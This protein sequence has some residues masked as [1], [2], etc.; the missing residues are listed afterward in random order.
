[1]LTVAGAHPPNRMFGMAK[2][3]QRFNHCGIVAQLLHACIKRRFVRQLQIH[4][5]VN[6]PILHNT[7]ADFVISV[8]ALIP[9]LDFFT[10]LEPKIS[11]QRHCAA[12]E[13]I[14]IF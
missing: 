8:A 6:Q 9:A 5:L 12:V 1:M 14:A 11:R 2:I 7:A 13:Q 3:A 10:L 4:K